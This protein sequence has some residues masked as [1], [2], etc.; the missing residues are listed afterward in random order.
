MAADNVVSSY[1][2]TDDSDG[3]DNIIVSAIRPNESISQQIPVEKT[4]PDASGLGTATSYSVIA[5]SQS[6]NLG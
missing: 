5:L 3:G 1:G 4:P 2:P 6:R